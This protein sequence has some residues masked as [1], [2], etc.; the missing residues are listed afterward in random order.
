MTSTDFTSRMAGR[1]V[2]TEE[3]ERHHPR[4]TYDLPNDDDYWW[5]G[6]ENGLRWYAA[7]GSAKSFRDT[8]YAL[9]SIYA[10]LARN[11]NKTTFAPY[12]KENTV[13]FP[14][15]YPKGNIDDLLGVDMQEA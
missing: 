6:T 14:D 7:R 12:K 8:E 9:E 2:S 11:K 15:S 13:V 4:V 3:S 5:D 10:Q 1:W